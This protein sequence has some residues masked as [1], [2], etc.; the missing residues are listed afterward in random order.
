MTAPAELLALEERRCKAMVAADH[1]ALDEILADELVYTHSNAAVDTKESYLAGIKSGKWKYTSVERLAETFDLFGDTARVT[2]HIRL[3]LANPDG[4]SRIVN[5]RY[6]NVWLK[7]QGR[8]Q[9][10]AW[11]STPI[12]AAAH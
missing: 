12:P 7:R 3:T 5:S 9:M 1:A 6:L 4:S 11:Q 8:W 2:G 10:L